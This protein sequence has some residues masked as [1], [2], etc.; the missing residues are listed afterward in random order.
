M[1]ASY[2][3]ENA[4]FEQQML[5]G[6]LEVELIPQGTLAERIRAGGAGIPAFFTP[7][8]VGTLVA[9]GKEVR[10]FDG[11]R[12]VMERP[13]AAAWAG[14]PVA[15]VTLQAAAVS[16]GIAALAGALEVLGV[17]GRLFDK[18][19][20]GYGYTA[21]AVALLARLQPLALFP[22]ALFFAAL[23]AGSSRMQQEADGSYGLVLVV[24]AVVVLAS[25]ASTR[26]PAAREIP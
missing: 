7:T 2:V 3:G 17:L 14:V 24:Q 20:P 5:S 26:A 4:V 19:S 1:M 12:F 18:V 23:D 21:I 13:R 9:E 8:G 6:E 22:A 10:E 25:I 15:R 11:R 16:G